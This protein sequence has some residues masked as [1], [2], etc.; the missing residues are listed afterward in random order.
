MNL[1]VYVEKLKPNKTP[2]LILEFPVLK[3]NDAHLSQSNQTAALGN[4]SIQMFYSLQFMF[5]FINAIF[6][7]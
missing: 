4:L 2:S 6:F 3:L 7:I 5:Y 1:T